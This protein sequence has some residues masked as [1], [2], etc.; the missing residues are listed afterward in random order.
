MIF[1]PT[2]EQVQR[3]FRHQCILPIVCASTGVYKFNC[4]VIGQ[5]TYK[6]VWTPFTDKI[7][8]ASMQS[9]NECDEHT[10]ND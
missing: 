8:S 6:S 7:V 5:Y 4:L 2:F 1:G 3:I 10:V 9:D